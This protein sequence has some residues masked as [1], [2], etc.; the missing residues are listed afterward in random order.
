WEIYYAVYLATLESHDALRANWRGTQRSRGA[1]PGEELCHSALSLQVLFDPA[2]PKS[3]PT[4]FHFCAHE[5]TPRERGGV[6]ARVS[7]PFKDFTNRENRGRLAL[8]AA[9]ALF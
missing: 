9:R 1:V 7:H 6:S 4:W 2:L 8:C 5:W 3:Y